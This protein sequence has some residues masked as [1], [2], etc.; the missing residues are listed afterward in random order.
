MSSVTTP[1]VD[2][3][4]HDD[5]RP[6]GL[7]ER[8]LGLEPVPEPGAVGQAASSMSSL[9]RPPSTRRARRNRP[10]PGRCSSTIA[11]IDE[12]LPARPCTARPVAARA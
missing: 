6:E 5:L 11:G 8:H 1:A 7:D 4:V 2:G 9:R 3:E 10:A 12:P